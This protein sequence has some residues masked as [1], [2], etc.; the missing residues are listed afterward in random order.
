[1]KLTKSNKQKII[2]SLN[3]F[4][5]ETIIDYY[6]E[7]IENSEF[8]NKDIANLSKNEI[9]DDFIEYIKNTNID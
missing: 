8:T 5:I 3:N 2:N 4:A 6:I 9:I 7:E 1:M